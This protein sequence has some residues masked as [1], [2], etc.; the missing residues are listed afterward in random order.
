MISIKNIFTAFVIIGIF[1]LHPSLNKGPI[2]YLHYLVYGNHVNLS[3]TEIDATQISVKWSC[4]NYQSN[5][6]ELVIYENGNMINDIPFEKGIQQIDVYYNNTL[7]GT[8]QQNKEHK[9]QA[10]HYNFN[11]SSDDEHIS[12]K[13]EIS[14]PSPSAYSQTLTKKEIILAKL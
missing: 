5:C 6:K 3:F 1:S 11:V 2:S 7:I 10:H 13:G 12:F 4:E 8:L 14:G 9:N